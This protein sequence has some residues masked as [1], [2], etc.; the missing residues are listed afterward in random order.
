MSIA[1]SLAIRASKNPSGYNASKYSRIQFVNWIFWIAVGAYAT[2]EAIIATFF[3]A[4][5]ALGYVV[6]FVALTVYFA[7]IVILRNYVQ[8]AKQFVSEFLP[9]Y[10]GLAP[11]QGYPQPMYPGGVVSQP[12]YPGGG[13][14]QQGYPAG[15]AY[16]GQPYGGQGY[17]G[18][19]G[20]PI[21]AQQPFVGNPYV[22]QN[23]DNK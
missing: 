18:Q 16:P 11:N 2:V 6:L 21:A 12:I 17:Y 5:S 8:T 23:P 10:H 3:F 9:P 1:G 7:G 22:L 19:V 4:G 20:Q 15:S 14:P 13:F